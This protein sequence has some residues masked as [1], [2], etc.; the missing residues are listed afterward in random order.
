MLPK[1]IDDGPMKGRC[2]F[3]FI[4]ENF[5]VPTIFVVCSPMV[6]SQ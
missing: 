3:Y 6:G 2:E 4:L 1:I 5:D